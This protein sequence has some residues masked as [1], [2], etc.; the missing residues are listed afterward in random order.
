MPKKIVEDR[1]L[2]V[3]GELVTDHVE[4]EHNVA[5]SHKSEAAGPGGAWVCTSHGLGFSSPWFRDDHIEKSFRKTKK[6]C[7]MG[8]YCFEHHTIEVP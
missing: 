4:Q 6:P 8:W 5:P 1:T 7:K 3:K 2:V